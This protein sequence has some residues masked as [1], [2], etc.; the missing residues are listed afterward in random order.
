MIEQ[1][2]IASYHVPRINGH[3]AKM[4]ASDMNPQMKAWYLAGAEAIHKE[5]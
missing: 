3:F 1:L 5:I 2:L 4:T